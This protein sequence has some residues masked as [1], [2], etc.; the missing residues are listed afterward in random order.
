MIFYVEH[1]NPNVLVPGQKIARDGPFASREEAE[2][3]VDRCEY[4]VK[5][6]RYKIVSAEESRSARKHPVQPPDDNG[7]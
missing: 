7:S 1:N 6:I 2:A 3:H 4:P 5:G